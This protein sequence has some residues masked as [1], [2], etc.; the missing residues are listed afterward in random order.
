MIRRAFLTALLLAA[1]ATA[2]GEL[3]HKFPV[4]LDRDGR[5]EIVALKPFVQE[6]VRLGQLVVL[7]AA[8]RTLWAGP[9]KSATPVSPS[10]PLVFGGEFD[11]GDIDLVADVDGDG[12]VELLGT[13]Q[14]SDVSPTRFRMLR[15]KGGK[16]VHV[17]SGRLVQ[18]P[19]RPGT[20]VWA[21]S[22]EASVWI[23]AFTGLGPDGLLKV[24][25]LD[26]RD[27]YRQIPETVH[28]TPEGVTISR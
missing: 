5:T 14:K 26:L 23:D 19:Q 2:G 8:G 3:T 11:L 28:V 22:P 7:D 1:P 6:G 20:F 18:A 12:A 10:E 13:Y 21:A 15:W 17:K 4:D 27:D 25:I 9:R 24:R 16:F